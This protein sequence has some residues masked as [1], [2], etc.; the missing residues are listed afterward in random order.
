MALRVGYTLEWV[1]SEIGV[2]PH[3]IQS[4]IKKGLL[5]N[6]PARGSRDGYSHEFV[7]QA[8]IVH[9]WLQLYPRG[10]LENLRDMLY[11]ESDEEDVA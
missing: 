8:L 1:A 4:W 5:R 7:S 9:E 2:S 11:P 10:P 3:T 6:G